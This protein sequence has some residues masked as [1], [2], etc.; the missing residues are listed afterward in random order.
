MSKGDIAGFWQ[1]LWHGIIAPITFVVSLFSDSVHVYEVHNNGNWYNFGFLLG[2][3]T[4]L[5]GGGGERQR[6]V[7]GAKRPLPPKLWSAGHSST[8]PPLPN[9]TRHPLE[10]APA[11]E[12]APRRG[13]VHDMERTVTHE[14]IICRTVLRGSWQAAE[15]EGAVRAAE[16][17]TSGVLQH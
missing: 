5:G 15:A 2:V 10:T 16:R 12:V 8:P 9:L 13:N 6:G 1:G 7:R 11:G 14:R 17:Q 3:A 4:I